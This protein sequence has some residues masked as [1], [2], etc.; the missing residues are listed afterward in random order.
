MPI[1]KNAKQNMPKRGS[2]KLTPTSIKRKR[3]RKNTIKKNKTIKDFK[4][5][6]FA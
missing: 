5:I 3:K 2:N 4:N 6:Y 1:G